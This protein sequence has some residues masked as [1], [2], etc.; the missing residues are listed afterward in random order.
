[1][2]FRLHCSRVELADIRE[3]P[4][5]FREDA[6]D[7]ECIILLDVSGSMSGF[8]VEAHESM[9]AIKNA[10]DSIQA[11]TTVVAYSDGSYSSRLLYSGNEKADSDMRVIRNLYGTD[12]YKALQYA[13]YLLAGSTRA[14]KLLIVI[15][16]GMWNGKVQESNE[17][18]IDIRN[19]GVIT[20]LA[21]LSPYNQTAIDGHGCEIVSHVTKPSDLFDLGQAIVEVGINRQLA[22]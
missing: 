14:I 10:L 12:P 6:T 17:T 13:K 19:G 20:T 5:H 18:I 1:V 7:I 8:E 11:S 2:P 21:Y 15:T 22:H 3:S 9:W 16:D 4:I